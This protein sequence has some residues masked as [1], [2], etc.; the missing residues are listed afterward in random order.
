MNTEKTVAISLLHDLTISHKGKV[1]W[2]SSFEGLQ[3][4]VSEALSLSDGKWST[5][6]GHAKLYKNEDT[7]IRWYSD[8]K[9]ITLSGNLAKEFEE[10][11]NSMAS[12]SQDLANE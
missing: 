3:S 2:T 4:F 1:V 6:R 7:A 10:N 9:W 12:I 8:T 5:P 11:L